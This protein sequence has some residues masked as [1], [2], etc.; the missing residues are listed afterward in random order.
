MT[1]A[2]ILRAARKAAGLNQTELARLAGTSQPAISALERGAHDPSF[3]T[4]NRILG[5][6]GWR[7]ISVPSTGLPAVDAAALI[8]TALEHGD[9]ASAFRSLV[10]IN[11]DLA[12]ERGAN[13]LALVLTAPETTGHPAWDAAL[14]GVTE[15]R[16]NHVGIPLPDWTRGVRVAEPTI[17]S[18]SRRPQPIRHDAVPQELLARNVL[19]ERIVLQST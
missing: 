10:Q 14:A 9:L 15:Y 17:V 6:T 7:L 4:L 12:A 16:L 13:R 8:A 2:I 19:I 11:D 3:D 1:A 18:G 5:H